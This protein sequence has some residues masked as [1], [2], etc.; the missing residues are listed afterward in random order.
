MHGK[1][2]KNVSYSYYYQESISG[3]LSTLY[4]I[5]QS[6]ILH[7]LCSYFFTENDFYACKFISSYPVGG[8]LQ[9]FAP[10]ALN[11]TAALMQLPVVNG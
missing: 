10:S 5:G 11:H 1:F 6:C 8:Y 9:M 7:S 3:H 4:C 2:S